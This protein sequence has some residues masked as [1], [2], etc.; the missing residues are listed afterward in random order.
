MTR[1]KKF[2]VNNMQAKKID[3]MPYRTS[4]ATNLNVIKSKLAHNSLVELRLGFEENEFGTKH[5]VQSLIKVIKCQFY[6]RLSLHKYSCLKSICIGWRLPNFALGPILQVVI[7]L[8]LIEPVRIIHIQLILNEKTSVPEECL[9]R[10]VSWPTLEC[11][12]L[13]SISLR[14]RVPQKYQCQ[15]RTMPPSIQT[16]RHKK[17]LHQL[18]LHQQQDRET[19]SNNIDST[20]RNGRNNDGEWKQANVVNIIPYVSLSVKT[21]KLMDCSINQHHIVKLCQFIRLRMH[22]LKNL[23]L[24]QN[25]TLDGG[26]DDLFSLP[27]IKSLDISLCDLD[28]TDGCTIGECILNRK[29]KNLDRLSLAGNYRM[30]NTIPDVV[31]SAASTLKELD[32]SFCGL[33]SKSQQRVFDNLANVSTCSIESVRMQGI[34][35]NDVEGLVNCVRNNNSLRH[36]VIDHPHETYSISAKGANA[37]LGAIKSNYSIETLTLDVIPN[38]LLDDI[39]KEIEFWL[40][41]NRCGRRALLQTNNENY[42]KSWAAIL[43]QGAMS[44]DCNIMFWLLRHGAV[45]FI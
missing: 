4:C 20:E 25:F 15:P 36:L 38:Q 34:M 33:N 39:L 6:A 21:L 40:K 44:N 17:I 27:C 2:I 19:N 32:C 26:Y 35:L 5:D 8:L 29:N 13:R 37:I 45:H 18:I 23:S 30:S 22:G 16:T 24:R 14:V 43:S 31:L 12:D 7:P 1:I 41:L 3:I 9:R 42:V 11:L 10:I 28:E